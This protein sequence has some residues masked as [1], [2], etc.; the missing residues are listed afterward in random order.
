MVSLSLCMIVKNE[1]DVLGRCLESVKDLADEIIIVDTGSDDHTK[2]IA[3][4]YTEQICDFEWRDDFSAARNFA[5]S[6]G[7]KDFLM[8]LDADDVIP[9]GEAE[10]FKR[11]KETLAPDTDV[12]M[13]PYAVSF[14]G[15]G[16]ST[17]YLLQRT[18]RPEPCG[19]LL[20]GQSA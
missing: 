1:E 16:R 9:G 17:I 2:E 11:F 8:W 18:D 19:I 13:M 12:V 20:S 5:F 15:A 3:A 4:H 10:R 14:D 6:K 7:T